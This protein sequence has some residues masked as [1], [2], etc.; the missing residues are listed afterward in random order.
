MGQTTEG[1]RAFH[2]A[3]ATIKILPMVT[4]KA[5]GIWFI[6]LVCAV[7]NGAFREAVL[8]PIFG[9]PVALPAS[10]LLLTG[11]IVA[12]SRWLL[13]RLGRLRRLQAI[14]IGLFW[15]CLTLAFEFGFGRLV[16]HRPWEKLFEAYT[17]KNGDLW[18]LVLLAT[19]IAPILAVRERNQI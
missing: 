9:S 14:C 10:G 8:V 1:S 6:I 2:A 7:I 15:L 12:V 18:P 4:L 5:T 13:P 16:L 11:C 19:L 17:F 3:G